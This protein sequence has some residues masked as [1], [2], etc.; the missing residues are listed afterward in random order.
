MSGFLHPGSVFTVFETKVRLVPLLQ[1]LRIFR[2]HE[3][4]TDSKNSLHALILSDDSGEK[5]GRVSDI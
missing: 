4:A 5:Q 3:I 2:P 1:S